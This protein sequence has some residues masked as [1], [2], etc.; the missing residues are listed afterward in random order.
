MFTRITSLTVV[1]LAL[2]GCASLP[3]D[4]AVADPEAL[5]TFNEVRTNPDKFEGQEAVFGGNIVEVNNGT[6][7]TTIE[8]L[9]LPLYSSGRPKADKD[10]S[11][12]RFKVAFPGFLDP[13]V[14]TK[15]RQLTVRGILDGVEKGR[16]G[17]HPYEFVSLKGS[18]L[19]LWDEL[20]DEVEVRYIRG[21]HGYYPYY[22]DPFVTPYP[23]RIYRPVNPGTTKN[24]D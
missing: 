23:I 1:L 6:D 14:F 24:K 13:E 15:G 7:L 3:D 11:G 17:E 5:P 8:V 16:I 4:V 20:T 10:Q 9:Q 21:I 18:G 2:T 19:Y 12:G 22:S